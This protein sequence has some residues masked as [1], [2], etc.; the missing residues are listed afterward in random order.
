[1]DIR[2]YPSAYPLLTPEFIAG[3]KPFTLTSSPSSTKKRQ[4]PVSWQIG[5]CFSLAILL[6]SI[7]MERIPFALSLVS[8]SL[9]D[10]IADRISFGRL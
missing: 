3:Y 7:R 2:K 4:S 10:I 9:A 8:D 5:I 6:F 1:M